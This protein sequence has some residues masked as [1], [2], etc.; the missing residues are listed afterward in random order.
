M[1]VSLQESG[2]PPDAHVGPY[3]FVRDDLGKLL[4]IAHLCALA[5]AERYGAFLNSPHGHY[6]LWESWRAGCPPNG[7]A[8]IVR[9]TEY[10]EWPRGRVVFDAVRRKFLVY[11]DPQIFRH[12]LQQCV[13]KRFEIPSAMAVFQRD[14]HYASTHRLFDS[15]GSR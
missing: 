10:E 1:V 3:W 8:G 2:N 5:D 15:S 11:A 6:D 13:L 7:I 4:L 9:D 12:D 14:E